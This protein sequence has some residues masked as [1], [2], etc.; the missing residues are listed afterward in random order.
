MTSKTMMKTAVIASTT[1]LGI[2][3]VSAAGAAEGFYIGGSA[4]QSHFDSAEFDVEDIDDEDYGWKVMGGLRFTPNVAAEVTYTDF[5]KENAPSASIG[6]PFEADAEAFSAFG[7]LLFPLGPVDLFAKAGASRIDAD[8]NVGAV[9][10]DDHD[11]IFAYGAGVQVRFNNLALRADYEKYDTDVIGDLD[12][13][14]IGLTYTFP[15]SR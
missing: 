2:L 11:T 14:A 3:G 13:I 15:F 1:W 12:V 4:Q 10:F 9:F 6:G 5:G 7:L 8:G